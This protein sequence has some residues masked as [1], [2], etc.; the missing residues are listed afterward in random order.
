MELNK[1]QNGGLMQALALILA[2]CIFN[3][4]TSSFI[5]IIESVANHF[6]PMGMQS[7]QVSLLQTLPSLFYDSGSVRRRFPEIQ[8][9]P[10]NPDHVWLGGCMDFF[11]LLLMF[12]DQYILFIIIRACMGFGLGIALPQPKAIVAKLYDGEKRASLIGYISMVGGVISLLIS[13]SLGYVAAVNWRFALLLY[14]VFAIV[15]IILVGLFVPHLPPENFKA[16][17]QPGEKKKEPLN[18]FVWALI[19]AGFFSFIICSV[20][21]VKTGQLVQE[22]GFGGSVE[23]GWVSACA[24][25]GTFHRRPYL[26]PAVSEARALDALHLCGVCRGGL[27]CPGLCACAG[28]GLHRLLSVWSGIRGYH[29]PLSGGQNFLRGSQVQKERRHHLHHRQHL[30]GA[31]SSAPCI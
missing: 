7:T 1:K 15:V 3:T 30:W 26:W 10:E 29:Q 14:P 23:T 20:I 5:V 18:K 27:F 8:V 9:Q 25:L 17:A 4:N 24:T 19:I 31:S 16:T 22:R 13:I 12:I 28:G 21:Q 6:G 2:A 11:G